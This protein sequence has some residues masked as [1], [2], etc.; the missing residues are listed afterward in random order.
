MG[1]NEKLRN[2]ICLDQLM[3]NFCGKQFPVIPDRIT[4]KPLFS[5]I[6]QYSFSGL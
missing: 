6:R 1:A 5:R 4:K 2:K 3:G